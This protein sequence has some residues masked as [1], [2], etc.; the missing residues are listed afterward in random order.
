MHGS[1]SSFRPVVGTNTQLW[2]SHVW[3]C[4]TRRAQRVDAES[5]ILTG[6]TAWIGT[7]ERGNAP[8]DGSGLDGTILLVTFLRLS[9]SVGDE[10]A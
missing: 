5:K 3:R 9:R 8:E 2:A 10:R 4:V 1:W 7:R 6:S